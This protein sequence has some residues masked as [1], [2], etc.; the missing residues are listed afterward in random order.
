LLAQSGNFNWEGIAEA[1]GRYLANDKRAKT[2]LLKEFHRQ[3]LTIRSEKIKGGGYQVWVVGQ[4]QKIKSDDP[5][6]NRNLRGYRGTRTRTSEYNRRIVRPAY[7]RAPPTT[8]G[9][10][11]PIPRAPSSPYHGPAPRVKGPGV[12]QAVGNYLRKRQIEK[13]RER[14]AAIERK[15]NYEELNKK[16]EQDRIKQ[17]REETARQV[18]KDQL[19][20]EAARFERQQHA[21]KMRRDVEARELSKQSQA[22]A[23]SAPV[24]HSKPASE[25][26]VSSTELQ[27]AR[28]DYVQGE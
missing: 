14:I 9:S 12:S 4:R 8:S 3:G 20:A 6:K 19:H 11:R 10:Y 16:L 27:Q 23:A 18:Q 22:S 25:K 13:E 2:R 21:E 24:T 17:E 1:D 5:F 26:H 28:E 15:K 7:R